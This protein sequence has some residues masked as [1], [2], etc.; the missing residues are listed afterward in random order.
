MKTFSNYDLYRYNTM[1]LHC[2]AKNVYI[3]ENE[4]ELKKL[5]LKF[6]EEQQPYRMLGACSNVVLPPKLKINLVLLTSF[7]KGI[8]INNGLI[9]CGASVRVQHLI[10]E[11]QKQG[12]GGIEYLFSVPCS[13]GG[14]VVMNA[15][16]GREYQQS[17]GNYVEKVRCLNLE[18]GKDVILTKDQCGYSYRNSALLHAN[19]VVLS[20][21]LRLMKCQPQ[22]IEERIN[23]R[24]LFAKQYLDDCRPS[25]G[26]IFNQFDRRIMERL[27]GFR[28]GGAE[29]SKKTLDWVSNRGNAKNWEV[30]ILIDIACFIHKIL[31]KKYHLEV[32]IW[33]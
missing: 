5:I 22:I 27:K 20:V 15:G 2:I 28:I 31:L 19:F 1:R 21:T 11:A 29:W 6:V 3:P 14:A 33:K 17:I 7:N 16:R 32:E 23:E 4:L 9:E 8:I 12:L 24:K 25:C 30:R 26:S 13:V 10:R 18:N